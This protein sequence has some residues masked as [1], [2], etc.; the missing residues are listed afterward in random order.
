M[1]WFGKIVGGGVGALIGGPAGA[2][3]GFGLGTLFD[4]A[5]SEGAHG[6]DE[7]L[8]AGSQANT[9]A[10]ETGIQIVVQATTALPVSALCAIIFLSE[11]EQPLSPS[12]RSGDRFRTNDG[13][14]IIGGAVSGNTI[15]AYLP[16]GAVPSRVSTKIYAVVKLVEMR[17]GGAAVGLGQT[18]FLMEAPAPRPW[19][20]VELIEPLVLLAMR[21][22]R[23]DGVLH[24]E[25]IR[26]IRG[27][28]EAIFELEPR[29][30]E[31]LRTT[32]K[33]TKPWLTNG[34]LLDVAHRRLPMIEMEHV[35]E[36]LVGVA[37]A[38][39]A[40]FPS[41]VKV[42]REL[43]MGYYGASRAEWASVERAL[44]LGVVQE[45]VREVVQVDHWTVLGL[46]HGATRIEIKKAYHVK[47]L[48]YHPDKVANLAEEFQELAHQKTIE[49]RASYEALLRIVG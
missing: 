19:C 13:Q 21:V 6:F 31:A 10:D 9:S 39:G 46:S 7:G 49:I 37:H 41:E 32:M 23:A 5:T 4:R 29:D 1:G 40:I 20:Q 44:G 45:P 15:L 11:N 36:L 3:V 8:L 28:M 38:D 16:S 26:Q 22:A 42:I 34:E 18:P 12:R 2:A 33:S 25:E 24:R 30:Q 47:M 27:R 48:A 14:L 17:S 43:V 35:I